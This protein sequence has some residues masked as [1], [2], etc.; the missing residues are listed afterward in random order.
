MSVYVVSYECIDNVVASLESRE[1]RRTAL[2][3][4]LLALNTLAFDARYGRVTPPDTQYEFS[5]PR[6]GEIQQYKSLQS[7]LYQVSDLEP[8]PGTR[9]YELLEQCKAAMALLAANIIAS[10]PEYDRAKWG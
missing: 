8:D 10:V 7:Y 3:R 9:A 1:S 2:G 6:R 5:P 4:E